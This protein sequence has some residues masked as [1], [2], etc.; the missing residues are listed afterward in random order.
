MLDRPGF[1]FSFSG[2]KTAVS[3]AAQALPLDQQRRADIARGV[4]EAIVDIL[5][6]KTLRAVEATGHRHLVV[7]GGVGANR[8]LRDR[9]SAKCKRAAVRRIFRGR[10]SA[11]TMRR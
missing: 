6:I 1:E 11:P 4:Q 7:A 9:L 10:S 2:L 3:L 8:E 5:C